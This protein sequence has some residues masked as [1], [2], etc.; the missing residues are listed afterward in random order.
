MLA[1]SS[2][3]LARSV[4][5][6]CR[7]R[8]CPRAARRFT[9]RRARR[10]L[11]APGGPKRGLRPPG[12]AKPPRAT[13]PGVTAFKPATLSKYGGRAAL[14]SHR[15]WTR[16]R[17]SVSRCARLARHATAADD[18][19]RELVWRSQG[20]RLFWSIRVMRGLGRS[21]RAASTRLARPATH[22]RLWHRVHTSRASCRRRP[23]SPPRG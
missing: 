21:G 2:A 8:S 13:R 15:E 19:R 20:E 23:R 3:Y 7:C 10:C 1:L 5:A 9:A 18:A 17:R 4:G 6:R 11:R 16:A 12:A 14:P 22:R